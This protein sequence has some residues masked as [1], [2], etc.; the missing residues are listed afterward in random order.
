LGAGS[1]GGIHAYSAPTTSYFANAIAYLNSGVNYSNWYAA[2]SHKLSF[3][4]SCTAPKTGT[5]FI[6]SG[7][8]ASDPRFVAPAAGSFRLIEG[9]PCI[10]AGTNAAWMAGATDLDGNPRIDTRF[11]RVDIGA[12]EYRWPMGTLVQFL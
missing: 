1:A 6:G 2:G 8:I 3:T 7:N 12:Y 10:N 4:N 11:Q 5:A 9:S